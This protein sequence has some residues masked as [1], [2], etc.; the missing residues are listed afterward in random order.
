M[1]KATRDN[2]IGK[3]YENALCVNAWYDCFIG[4]RLLLHCSCDHLYL[5]RRDS[6]IICPL[7]KQADKKEPAALHEKF[8]QDYN[9]WEDMIARCNNPK[10]AKYPNYGGRGIRVCDRWRKYANFHEDMGLRPSG[11]SLDRIDNNGNYEPGNCR[12]ATPQEQARN[13]RSNVMITID[14]ETHCLAEWVE[15]LGEPREVLRRRFQ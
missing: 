6:L 15:I 11:M 12:W 7:C 8:P 1:K 4:W 9:R 5:S 3:V 2:Y 14:G 10:H 13:R